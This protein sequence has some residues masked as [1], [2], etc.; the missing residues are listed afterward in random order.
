MQIAGL[1]VVVDQ[2]AMSHL[3]PLVPGTRLTLAL[4]VHTPQVNSSISM[5][6]VCCRTDATKTPTPPRKSSFHNHSLLCCNP[7][8]L[9][10]ILRTS[11]QPAHICRVSEPNMKKL[12]VLQS[13]SVSACSVALQADTDA[14]IG[15]TICAPS[16]WQ[17]LCKLLVEMKAC[18]HI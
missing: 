13:A 12:N 1:Q 7:L 14:L 10:Y 8:G 16:A 2:E 5:S 6:G 15:K 9:I 3:L 18:F 4:L 17:V 11:L